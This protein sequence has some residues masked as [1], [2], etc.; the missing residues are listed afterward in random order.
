MAITDAVNEFVAIQPGKRL[1]SAADLAA[2]PE[3][4]PSGSVSYELHHG[5][6][7][8]M[9]P[10]GARHGNLQLRLGGAL[11][12]Q[13]EMKGYGRAYTEVGVVLAR[14]PDHVFGAD[15]AFVTNRSFPVKESSEGYLETIPELVAEIRSKNDTK[16]ELE[17]KI[18][19]YLR[20]GVLLVWLVDPPTKSVAEHRPNAQPRTLRAD[21]VLTCDD[22]ICGFRLPL[23]E[24]FSE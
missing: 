14:N 9:S 19:D 1:L 24:L 8:P 23:P 10:P 15:A 17:E 2:L 20:A 22:I 3:Y 5:R 6:L 21:D 12:A 7:V 18:A 13:G 4:L 11:L 16:A